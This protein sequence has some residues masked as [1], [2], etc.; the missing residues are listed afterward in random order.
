[1]ARLEHRRRPA[2]RAHSRQTS[3]FFDGGRTIPA[4]NLDARQ[5]VARRQVGRKH[6]RRVA[7]ERQPRFLL[8]RLEARHRLDRTGLARARSL[9]R[10]P[11]PSSIRRGRRC[12]SVTS[13]RREARAL[14]FLTL[15]ARISATPPIRSASTSSEWFVP[16]G[17]RLLGR[18]NFL[19]GARVLFLFDQ[20]PRGGQQRVRVDLGVVVCHVVPL[21][22]TSAAS[23][24]RPTRDNR[25][26]WTLKSG[27][28]CL[29][30]FVVPAKRRQS[31]APAENRTPRSS[32]R[33]RVPASTPR[34]LCP[35]CR[36]RDIPRRDCPRRSPRPASGSP[37]PETVRPPVRTAPSSSNEYPCTL[38]TSRCDPRSDPHTRQLPRP[39]GR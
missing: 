27:D 26:A 22:R 32:D 15:P 33:W 31:E 34:A 29:E 5:P 6:R 11:R 16:V 24:Y 36:S 12:R 39:P 17:E 23:R 19:E 20:Q 38:L 13:E 10:A 37:R 2:A 35:A 1:M 21:S 25:N 4:R 18:T 28:C 9:L 8:R 7:P 3:V 30:R 14:A